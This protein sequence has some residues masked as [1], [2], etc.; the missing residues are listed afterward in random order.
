AVSDRAQGRQEQADGR[1]QPQDRDDGQHDVDDAVAEEA[2]EALQRC[3]PAPDD[4]ELAHPFLSCLNR[5]TLMIIDG[6]TRMSSSSAS[7]LPSPWSLPPPN[8]TVHISTAITFAAGFD[9]PGGIT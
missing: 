3:L 8:D 7:A 2:E 9:E 1:H 6:S 4:G 5:R